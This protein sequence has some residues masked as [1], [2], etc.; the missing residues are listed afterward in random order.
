ME[1]QFNFW[2]QIELELELVEVDSNWLCDFFD[3]CFSP[4]SLFKE[5]AKKTKKCDGSNHHPDVNQINILKLLVNAFVQ[6][7]KKDYRI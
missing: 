6:P 2:F 7:S 5:R 4:I 3:H 1:G